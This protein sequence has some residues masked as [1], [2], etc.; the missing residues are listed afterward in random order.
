MILVTGAGGSVGSALV[1]QLRKDGHDVRAAY[2]S[3]AATERA[4]AAGRDAVTIDMSDTAT[5]GPALDGVSTVFLLGATSSEQ[6]TRELNV[7]GSAVRAGVTRMVKLSVWRADEELTPIARLHRP[8]ERGLAESPLRWTLLRPN[9]YMQTFVRAWAEGIRTRG[10]FANALIRSPISFVDVADVARVAA[11][12]L[13][14]DGHDGAAYALTGPEAL[15]FAEAAG[16]LSRVLGRPVRYDGL[17]DERA[18]ALLTRAGMSPF[19]TEALI[20][21][22][23]AYRDGGAEAVLPTVHDITGQDPVTFERFAQAHRD[24]FR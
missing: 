4:R 9:F 15:T 24:A 5:L 11:R 7:V 20:D 1:D 22:S 19:E 2:H 12:I 18:R 13:T 8:V 10:V 21:V 17:S 16:V 14:E 6:T 3:P 23:R